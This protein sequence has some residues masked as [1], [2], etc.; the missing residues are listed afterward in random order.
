MSPIHTPK[1][2]MREMITPYLSRARAHARARERR[3]RQRELSLSRSLESRESSLCRALERALSV[4]LSVARA[5]ARALSFSLFRDSLLH[6]IHKDH[7]K[8]DF[9][10]LSASLSLSFCL[11]VTNWYLESH[12]TKTAS[13]S[14][15]PNHHH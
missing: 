6:T 10:S 5:V 4:T 3:A 13:H 12:K 8:K 14:Y 9:H 15:E 1:I 2:N 11:S 7:A